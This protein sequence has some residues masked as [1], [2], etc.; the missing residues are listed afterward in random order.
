MKFERL[1]MDDRQK[2]P[3]LFFRM[4]FLKLGFWT[5]HYATEN[6]QRIKVLS[7]HFPKQNPRTVKNG[8]VIEWTYSENNDDN[9]EYKSLAAGR[10]DFLARNSHSTI[11]GTFKKNMKNLGFDI[12]TPKKGSKIS[13]GIGGEFIAN[14]FFSFT[15]SYESHGI[16]MRF[17]PLTIGHGVYLRNLTQDPAL[18][19]GED[20]SPVKIIT[21]VKELT[22]IAKEIQNGQNDKKKKDKEEKDKEEK[23]INTKRKGAVSVPPSDPNIIQNN[24]F[25][26]ANEALQQHNMNLLHDDHQPTEPNFSEDSMQQ[27][28]SHQYCRKPE[29]CLDLIDEIEDIKRRSGYDDCS[30]E[31]FKNILIEQHR[32]EPKLNRNFMIQSFRDVTG[33]QPHPTNR[34]TA[35][36]R[37]STTGYSS[38]NSNCDPAF[39]RNDSRQP[40]SGKTPMQCHSMNPP[41]VIPR[42]QAPQ[43]SS[44]SPF[45]NPRY[46]DARYSKMRITAPQLD[47]EHQAFQLQ[48]LEED[49][50]I[51]LY[52]RS[53]EYNSQQATHYQEEWYGLYVDKGRVS[54][55]SKKSSNAP[56]YRYS[57]GH[58]EIDG[59][60]DKAPE[61]IPLNTHPSANSPRY[62]NHKMRKQDSTYQT[63]PEF[64]Q[65][66][67]TG[68]TRPVLTRS[69]NTLEDSTNRLPA[70]N[71][72]SGP[73]DVPNEHQNRTS[74]ID[75]GQNELDSNENK[76]DWL[77]EYMNVSNRTQMNPDAAQ[78]SSVHQDADF[79]NYFNAESETE[80]DA[81]LR[82]RENSSEPPPTPMPDSQHSRNQV[83]ATTE[84]SKETQDPDDEDV[85]L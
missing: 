21:T 18:R 1:E 7:L 82:Q 73:S 79:N 48:S 2:Y 26:C 20:S 60:N 5:E 38:N 11:D 40:W 4:V 29:R 43:S 63:M 58:E 71:N 36:I 17:Q 16:T 64:S 14:S 34:V 30:V 80:A 54:T 37:S 9:L 44:K 70:V 41:S 24:F 78:L 42:D 53:F 32:S 35:T 8:T 23:K 75:A 33:I 39:H 15:H 25:S 68:K 3:G 83:R 67:S 66:K 62:N 6:Q 57:P 84:A 65:S 61:V 76:P 77:D 81:M 31:E 47:E 45:N 46:P 22:V 27:P 74:N 55:N 28:A 85:D 72:A 51:N 52:D 10:R 50:R 12:L 13:D 19:P 69:G 59:R 56:E 49:R